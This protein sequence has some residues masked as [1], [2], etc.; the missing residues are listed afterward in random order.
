MI[1]AVSEQQA[2]HV[3]VVDDDAGL[4]EQIGAYLAEHGYE[5][6]LAADARELEQVLAVHPVDLIVLDVMLPGEDGLSVCRRL[7]SDGGPAIVM[8]SAMA[9]EVDRVLG[10][11]LGADDYLAKPCSPRE[12]LA[13][14]R[15]VLRRLDDTRSSGGGQRRGRNYHFLGFVVDAQRRQL[16]APSGAIVLLTSGEYSLLA[17]FLDHPQRILSR[18]Q[19]LEFARGAEAEV[20]DRAVDVQI[21]RLRRKLNACTEREIIKTYRGAGYLFDARVTRA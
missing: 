9:D 2:R 7:A 10:L 8:V 20:F 5:T 14:V 18:D 3:A 21:S 17:A 13:R 6:H 15:A 11:E 4:R 16:R 1:P 19:L 12:L